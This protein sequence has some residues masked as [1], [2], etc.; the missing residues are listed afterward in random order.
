MELCRVCFRLFH[1]IDVCLVFK[2]IIPSSDREPIYDSC[3]GFR[4]HLFAV[5]KHTRFCVCVAQPDTIIR[6]M[7]CSSRLADT[8]FDVKDA[9]S[10]WNNRECALNLI[11]VFAE[12]RDD[13]FSNSWFDIV[14]VRKRIINSLNQYHITQLN[15][16]MRHKRR[17]IT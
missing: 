16:R 1:A 17:S 6:K 11:M 15:L 5:D 13:Y 12:S 4:H 3:A 14:F 10:G 7:F 9:F 8:S 2:R